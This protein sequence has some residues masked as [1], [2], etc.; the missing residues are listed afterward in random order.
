MARG[1]RTNHSARAYKENFWSK[2][3]V[4]QNLT[5][6]QVADLL[7]IDDARVSMWFSGQYMPQDNYVKELCNLFDVDFNEG[8]LAFQQAHQVWKAEHDRELKYSAKGKVK[9][10]PRT[11]QISNIADVILVLYGEIPCDVFL[12]IYNA[13]TSGKP[14]ECDIE[15]LLYGKIEDYDLYRKVVD[16][17]KS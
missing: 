17:M 8:Q 14:N 11:K 7:G 13:V 4:E 5:I 15:K 9:K 6:E 1:N 16:I 2:Q 12:T 3:R 10:N